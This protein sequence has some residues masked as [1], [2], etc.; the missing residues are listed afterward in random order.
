MAVYV[1]GLLVGAA[2]RGL[3]IY[4][5]TSRY[6][7]TRGFIAQK[8]SVKFVFIM[9]AICCLAA[10]IGIPVLKETY[11]PVIQLKLEKRSL[12]PEKA[13]PILTP[14]RKNKTI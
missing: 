4:G 14:T 12:D 9:S 7:I 1:A 3:G 11:A 13:D 6:S 8:I 10:M 2:I 5:L